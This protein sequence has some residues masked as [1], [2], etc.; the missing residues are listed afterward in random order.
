MSFSLVSDDPELE[1]A[2]MLSFFLLND[3]AS[4]FSF[5]LR[6][7]TCIKSEG[8]SELSELLMDLPLLVCCDDDSSAV[9]T[10]IEFVLDEGWAHSGELRVALYAE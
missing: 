7:C 10:A 1:L 4:E 2:S 9:T 8:G 5:F 6:L 3:C